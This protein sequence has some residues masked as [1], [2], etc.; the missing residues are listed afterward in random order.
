MRRPQLFV[1]VSCIVG[2]LGSAVAQGQE[3]IIVDNGDPGTTA[4]GGQWKV[5]DARDAY[6]ETSLYE[7][8]AGATYTYDV[9]LSDGEYEVYV[10][11]TSHEKRRTDVPIEIEHKDGTDTVIVNQLENGGTWNLLGTH[12]FDDSAKI[13]VISDRSANTNCCADAVRLVRVSEPEPENLAPDARIVS[14]S[15]NPAVEGQLVSFTGA[16]NDPD[17]TIEAYRWESDVDGELSQQESF[18]TAALSTGMH[19]IVFQARDDDGAWSDP[20]ELTVEVT[21]ATGDSDED[22]IPDTDDNCPAIAN[23]A[24]DDLD[25]DGVGDACDNCFSVANPDQIDDNDNGLGDVCDPT[26]D[27]D[28]DGVLN[29]DDNCP[30][31]ANPAQTDSD[32]DGIGD[33]CD[34]P[35]VTFVRGD[36]NRDGTTDISDTVA[37]LDFYFRGNGD[38]TCLDAADA[39]DDGKLDLGDAIY[40]IRF[41]FSGGAAPPAPFPDAGIDPTLDELDECLF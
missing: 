41:A 24:Q 31:L 39:N 10:W 36:A 16:T 25:G 30:A 18:D 13:R 12:D 6:G 3:E 15:P 5:S 11:W 4:S 35:A 2:L 21:V 29:A 40:G 38:L 27:A 8:K 20:D 22:G 32:G 23:P 9:E 17:G 1:A 7:W 28:L 37:V 34:D 19:Q 33:A 26:L 14:V